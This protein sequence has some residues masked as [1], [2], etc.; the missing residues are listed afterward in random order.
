M[1]SLIA[2][3][4]HLA[5]T[6]PDASPYRSLVAALVLAKGESSDMAA[7]ASYIEG[8][9]G[10][11]DGSIRGTVITQFGDAR[12]AIVDG[13]GG[14]AIADE[15]TGARGM[16]KQDA[17][18][19]VSGRNV[20]VY[21]ALVSGAA[22][23]LPPEGARGNYGED[24]AAFISQG[25]SPVTGKPFSKYQGKGVFYWLGTQAPG[26][27]SFSGVKS[28]ARKEAA[29]RAADILRGTNI[30]ERTQDQ[31]DAP[32]HAGGDEGNEDLLISML[33]EEGV[34]RSDFVDLAA[35]IYND[36]WVMNIIDRDVKSV[37]NGERQLLI[38][39]LIRRFPYTLIVKPDGISV[40][41]ELAKEYAKA[42]GED[43]KGKSTDTA[44][45]KNFK[46]KILPAMEAAME[47]SSVAKRILKNRHILEVISESRKRPSRTREKFP[48]PIHGLPRSKSDPGWG[49]DPSS[50][51]PESTPKE[52]V[53]PW[54]EDAIAKLKRKLQQNTDWQLIQ[55]LRSRGIKLANLIRRYHEKKSW[56]LPAREAQKFKRASDWAHDNWKDYVDWG[57][58]KLNV[59]KLAQGIAT[60]AGNAAFADQAE[61]WVWE[62]AYDVQRKARYA[63]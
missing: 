29:H 52:F 60:K 8:L 59:D 20:G 39:D 38:W 40:G 31:L 45:R 16:S 42:L 18:R 1:R 50:V 62:I 44:V 17:L 49:I 13:T 37:L 23:A 15:L 35:A 19:M 41:R 11:P 24:I 51:P 2:D 30:G 12:D 25:Y 54:R 32:A 5:A 21:D 47:D 53:S 36:P 26:R 34:P 4:R 63:L 27:I 10:A 55:R 43:Y 57:N 14:N 58:G 61:H 22:G 3:L 48:I 6:V 7:R 9:L 28:I 56:G 33:P 46:T